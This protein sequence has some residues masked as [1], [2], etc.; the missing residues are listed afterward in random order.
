MNRRITRSL[1][2]AAAWALVLSGCAASTPEGG[3][4][5]DP[6]AEPITIR[7]STPTTVLPLAPL[8]IAIA[9]GYFEDEGLAVELVEGGGATQVN[10]SLRSGDSQ[11]SLSAS[12]DM[13]NA[14]EAGEEQIAV[15]AVNS[16]LTMQT[17]VSTEFME[18]NGLTDESSFE[19][20]V[21]ALEGASMGAVSLGG[22]H[23]IFLR[24][25]MVLAGVDPES[26]NVVRVGAGSAAIAALESEQIDGFISG[27]P[28]GLIAEQRGSGAILFDPIEIGGYDDLPW[29]VLI[30]TRSYAEANPAVVEAMARA[31]ARAME[32][33]SGD[34]A[35]S[36]ALVAEWFPGSSPELLTAAL[37]SI[38]SSFAGDGSMTPD[39][40]S[41][42][43]RPV[44]EAGL[45]SDVDVAEGHLWTNDYLSVP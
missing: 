9:E 6:D 7:V 17:I 39:Q 3:L 12:S 32:T 36:A 15:S 30:T 20:R 44:E 2:A 11:F 45:V 8:Y 34:P 28:A 42:A 14:I 1:V 35:A 29:Q 10:A 5:P 40:W 27:P 13:I 38:A 31:L 37:E 19:E 23:E 22:A 25:N 16:T 21:A 43:V 41:N 26:V 24:Y 4:T 33:A 18:R